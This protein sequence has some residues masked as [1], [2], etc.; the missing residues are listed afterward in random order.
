M[1]A[2]TLRCI[3]PSKGFTADGAEYCGSDEFAA[4]KNESF[5]R[6]GG[7]VTVHYQPDDP[8]NNYIAP[9]NT[10]RYPRL[11]WAAMVLLP[12]GILS[13]LSR[14]KRKNKETGENDEEV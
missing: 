7:T 4:E 14:L 10:D 11:K 13:T 8:D 5:Y 6:T 12:L 1:R 2:I 9:A 3:I